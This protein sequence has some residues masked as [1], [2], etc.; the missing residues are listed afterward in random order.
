MDTVRFYFSFRSPYAWLAFTR[1]DRAL[2][3]LPVKLE[4]IPVFPPENFEN[5]PAGVPVKLQYIKDDVERIAAAYG[6]PV[7]WPES[8]DTA[9]IRPHAAFL[10]AEDTGRGVAF[11]RALF[12]ARFSEGRDAGDDGVMREAA[13]RA[14]LEP[15]AIVKAADDPDV[16]QR[17]YAGMMG[18]VQEGLFGVPFFIYRGTRFWGNDRLEWL[19]REI[20]RDHGLS[21][22]D[23]SIDALVRP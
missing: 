5:D 15:E 19:V 18:G 11:G 23:L 13:A 4:R 17:V 22:P 6:L 10:R 9:W 20:R 14:G 21:V 12:A 16:Q 7:R 8:R 3:G 2:E 1:I